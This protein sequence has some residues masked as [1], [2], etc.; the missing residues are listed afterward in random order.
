MKIKH[1]IAGATII[2][3]TALGATALTQTAAE[4]GGGAYSEQYSVADLEDVPAA[5]KM[6]EP[7]WQF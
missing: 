4:A 5:W 3:A 1:A 2:I 6:A 7:G